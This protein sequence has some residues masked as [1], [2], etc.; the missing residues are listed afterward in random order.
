MKELI[1]KLLKSL[2]LSG[3]DWAALLLA[4][5]LAFSIWLIHNLSLKYNDFLSVPVVAQ[6]NLEGHSD[7]ATDRCDVVAR[8]RTTGYDAIRMKMKRNRRPIQITFRPDIM[9]HK[10]GDIFYVT[11]GDLLEYSH[12]IYGDDVTIEYFASDTLFFTFPSVEYK[13]VPVY[14][15]FTVSYKSQY[16]AV[17]DLK[18]EPDSVVLYG[19]PYRLE[20]IDKVFTKP[21]KRM[22][23]DSDIQ[24]VLGL[25]KLQNVRMSH[26]EVSYSLDVTR[27]VELKDKVPV[28]ERNVPAD[29]EMAVL[30]SRVEVVLKCSFPLKGDP[31][32]DLVLYVDY[33][34]FV[35]TVSGKCP[36][37]HDSFPEGV[38]GYDID[39]YYVECI[40]IDR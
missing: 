32:K 28:V 33:E 37:R 16:T 23:L 7:V 3:R 11:S 19:E 38:I 12:L 27:Y 14:P 40:V 35:R 25:K 34:D 1:E 22:D 20:N 9:K 18:L 39:P 10:K 26:D 31:L 21:L 24:G 13:K 2:G 15:A 29:K 36:I 17:G 4:L 6:C 8:C 30:P 5:L